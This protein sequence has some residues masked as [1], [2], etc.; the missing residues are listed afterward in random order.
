MNSV[1]L[2]WRILV[3]KFCDTDTNKFIISG[4][5]IFRNTLSPSVTQT[6]WSIVGICLAIYRI[7]Q[8]YSIVMSLLL[9]AKYC[10][11]IVLWDARWFP[12]P[13]S[14]WHYISWKC[15]NSSLQ[16]SLLDIFKETEVSL[17]DFQ[18]SSLLK[19]RL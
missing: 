9:W 4:I 15:I 7:S 13:K 18:S 19:P 14:R 16:I 6:L 3:V 12:P 10:A 2:Q 17:Y 5:C 1:N 11:N 8:N